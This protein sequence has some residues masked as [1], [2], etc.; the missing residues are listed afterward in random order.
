MKIERKITIEIEGMSCANCANGIQKYLERQGFNGVHVNFSTKEATFDTNQIQSRKKIINA[1]KSLGYSVISE[2]KKNKFSKVEKYFYFTL[3]FTLPL[4]SHMFVNRHNILHD[5]LIQFILC[6]PVYLIGLIYFGKSALNSL[7][8]RVPNMDVLIFIG[9]SSAFFYSIYGWIIFKGTLNIHN[10]LFFET[11]ATIITLV[12]LGNLLEQRSIKKTTT[13]ISDLSKIQQVIAKKEINGSIEKVLFHNIKLND[14]LIVNTGDKIP[15]D[16]VILSGT[17]LVDESMVTGESVQI[18]KKS[19]DEVIGGTIISEG[20][21]KISALKIGKDTLLSQIINLVKNAQN[22]K[23]NIQKLGDKVS[24]IFVPVVISISILTFILGHFYFG[25]STQD[26]FLRSIAVLV[27][28]CPCAMGLATPTAVMVGIGR[29]AKSGILIK[30][31]HTLE[32]L[33]NIKNIVLDKTGTITTGNFKLSKL[34]IIIGDPEKIKNIIYQIET[35][36][37]HPIAKSLCNVFKDHNQPLNLK[38]I[39]EVKGKSISANI[40]GEIYTIGS[41]RIKKVNNRHDLYV[42]KNDTLI[43]TLDIRDELKSNTK[44]VLNSIHKRGIVTYL[45]SGD[46]KAKCEVIAKYLEINHLYSEQLP[47]DKIEKIEKINDISP[48]AMIGDGINDAPALAMA[49]VGISL[50]NATQVAIQSSD[51]ILL[52]SENLEQ[53]PKVLSIGKH[54]L[55]T[56]KQN[57]FW[58]FAYNIVA[59][60]IAISGLLNPMWGALFMAFSDVIVIGNSIRLRYK[61]IY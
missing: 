45:L 10:Y 36:S 58:A 60:P 18:N 12:I 35:H 13:A 1:I 16:G 25:I 22:N 2:S 59:I 54:T 39:K 4:F 33:A 48:T 29:A 23:P 8:S 49:S 6:L 17:C 51:V 30:G 27:I 56:I 55:V 43:A 38:D 14:T 52:N 42:F 34:N 41:S 37:S 47:S 46:K 57:L 3:L 26:A 15:T 20:S 5:P 53:L 11:T 40:D 28:S 50:G 32:K 31:G 9:S 61:K 7:K 19:G 21:I 44:E 24:A